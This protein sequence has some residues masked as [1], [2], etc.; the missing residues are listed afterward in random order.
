MRRPVLFVLLALSCLLLPLG[1]HAQSATPTDYAARRAELARKLGPDAILVLLSPSPAVRNGDVGYP[2]RQEDNLL[3]LTGH[4]HPGASLVLAPGDAEHGELLFVRDGDPAREIWDGRIP[5]RDEVAKASGVRDV[6]SNTRFRAGLQSL[7]EGRTPVGGGR[8]APPVTSA[9]AIG[10]RVREGKA[11]LWL[12]M[13]ER[14]FE[15]GAAETPEQALI[16]DLRRSYPELQFRNAWPVLVGM[17]MVKRPEELKTL[18]RVIDITLEAQKAAMRRV[19]TATHEYQV[20]AAVEHAFRDR[21][22]DGWSFPSIAAGGRNA[23]TLHYQSNNDPITPGT[24]MLTDIGAELDGYAA[25]VTRTYPQSGVFSPAQ[26][27]VYEA[28]LRAQETS[29]AAMVPGTT[30]REVQ[31]VA[32]RSL[33]E[34]LLRMGLVTKNEPAQVRMYFLHG[35]GHHLGLRVHDV[36]EPNVKLAAG[37]LITNEPG[38]YVRPADVRANPAYLALSAAERAGVDAAL[39]KYADIGVRIEDDILIGA[40]APTNMSAAAPRTVADIEAF[41]AGAR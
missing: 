18:Q 11:Q 2:Y 15:E 41:M 28:V 33:G 26:R 24:L 25:D 23:T 3:Y 4:P 36:A 31:E 10:Q 6:L 13:E 20:Q 12:L 27:E 40:G 14:H 19:R 7:L 17:R 1:A 21:G 39:A 34:D 9:A 5:S 37:M 38:L 16:A 32:T 8:G 22:A 35:L 30:M 29:I